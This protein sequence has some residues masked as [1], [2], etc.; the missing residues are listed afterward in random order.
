MD[1]D[2]AE[3]SPIDPADQPV[4][5][6]RVEARAVEVAARFAVSLL[7]DNTTY[8]NFGSGDA[9]GAWPCCDPDKLSCRCSNPDLEEADLDV[10]VLARSRRRKE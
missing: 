7:E 8:T 10:G 2:P 1:S 4:L 3:A 9:P 6:A 5:Y